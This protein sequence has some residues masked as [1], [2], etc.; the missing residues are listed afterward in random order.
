MCR[1][2]RLGWSLA[3]FTLLLTASL[4]LGPATPSRGQANAA[5]RIGVV[6]S[7]F[8]DYPDAMLNMVTVPFSTLME[9]QTGVKGQI[10]LVKDA[11][12]LG[13]K[14]DHNDVQLG[15]FHGFEF[16]WAQEKFAQLRPLMIAVYHQRSLSAYLVTR[17]DSPLTCLAD[18]QGKSVA[19][20]QFSREHC[21]LFLERHCARRHL[22]PQKHFSKICRPANIEKALDEV[23]L[24]EVN[25][26]IVDGASLDCYRNIKP[27]CYKRLK[28][29][30]QSASFPA[31]AIAY[32]PGTLDESLLNRFR[33]G[34]LSASQSPQAQRIMSMCKLTAFEPIP[35]DYQQSLDSIRRAYP[36]PELTPVKSEQTSQARMP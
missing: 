27:G 2:R 15:V 4:V 21:W 18:C 35:A 22:C 34:L 5:I 12:E 33:A 17:N 20:P 36:A 16:A 31:A 9:A 23:V 1:W 3:L 29:V 32:R 24:G 8:R 26:V 14:L 25:G 13:D 7:L 30:E 28:I 6:K 19:I 10:V 11:I